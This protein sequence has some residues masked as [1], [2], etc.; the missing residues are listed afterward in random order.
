MN[1]DQHRDALIKIYSAEQGKATPG[2]FYEVFF[3]EAI[4][5]LKSGVDPE[6]VEDWVVN[7]EKA[8]RTFPK[9]PFKF[10]LF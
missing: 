10:S 5:K 8:W 7:V 9:K 6:A 1:E 2:G 4:R 3:K